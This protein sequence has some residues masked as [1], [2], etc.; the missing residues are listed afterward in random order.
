[1]IGYPFCSVCGTE[2]TLDSLAQEP[3]KCGACAGITNVDSI[4]IGPRL[5]TQVAWHIFGQ[6]C[7]PSRDMAIVHVVWPMVTIAGNP[8]VLKDGREFPLP[9]RDELPEPEG[10]RN[11]NDRYMLHIGKQLLPEIEPAVE[12]YRLIPPRYSTDIDYAML[13]ADALRSDGFMMTL[14]G[15]SVEFSENGWWC[16]F[17]RPFSSV[18]AWQAQ[19][20]ETPSEALCRAALK[21]H[22]CIP[23]TA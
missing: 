19:T 8:T 21:A 17:D 6:D 12:Q 22:L 20:I 5:D 15:N 3:W 11:G 4:P 23:E 13:V 2:T 18:H 7:K 1:M 9:P 14:T 16:S 10:A